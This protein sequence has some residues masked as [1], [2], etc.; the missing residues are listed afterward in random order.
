MKETNVCVCVGP[1]AGPYGVL[2]LCVCVVFPSTV[3]S[4]VRESQVIRESKEKQI[5]ELK[6][7]SDQSTDS[8]KNEWEK[9]VKES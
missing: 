3:Q 2:C 7:M 9:K 1:E 6:K 8:L 5:G 4:V